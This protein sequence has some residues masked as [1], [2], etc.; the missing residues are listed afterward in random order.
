[1]PAPIL[2]NSHR[3]MT[4]VGLTNAPIPV[5]HSVTV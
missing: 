4:L 5:D 3:A 1:M 2:Y